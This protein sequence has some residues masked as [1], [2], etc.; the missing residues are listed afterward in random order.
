MISASL[1]L[2]EL[3]FVSL[4]HQVEPLCLQIF[5]RYAVCARL[6]PTLVESRQI[7]IIYS[8][9]A[10]LCASPPH[11][12]A[13]TT[14]TIVNSAVSTRQQTHRKHVRHFL[15]LLCSFPLRFFSRFFS[16]SLAGVV[17]SRSDRRSRQFSGGRK[18]RGSH[19][20]RGH[21]PGRGVQD[22][23]LPIRADRHGAFR[24]AAKILL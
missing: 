14:L 11:L 9:R 6:W 2:S 18:R 1:V 24:C 20:T 23:H 3:R 19:T 5:V 22:T 15:L 8:P 13:V 12:R 17:L 21:L 10:R 7:N 4:P 16:H